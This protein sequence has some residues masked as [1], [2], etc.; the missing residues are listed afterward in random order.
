MGN[1]RKI[2]VIH[3]ARLVRNIICGKIRS[4]YLSAFEIVSVSSDEA[5]R[6]IF[7]EKYEIIICGK[8]ML[9]FKEVGLQSYC[10][11]SPDNQGIPIIYIVPPQSID[12]DWKSLGVQY[13][14]PSPLSSVSLRETI[15]EICNPRKWRS[16]ERFDVENTKINLYHRDFYTTGK[17]LNLSIGGVLFETY[18]WKEVDLFQCNSIT[19][20]FPPEINLQVNHIQ[21]KLLKQKSVSWNKKGDPISVISVLSFVNISDENLEIL[22]TAFDYFQEHSS[23]ILSKV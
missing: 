1:L 23:H 19:I 11:N 9:D 5:I 21:C 8:E 22:N 3:D 2:L 6:A 20:E 14:L 7:Q 16:G 13:V 17:V 10:S 15:N 12:D 4:E 18:Y